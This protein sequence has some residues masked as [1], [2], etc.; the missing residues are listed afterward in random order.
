MKPRKLVTTTEVIPY[1]ELERSRDSLAKGPRFDEVLFTKQ[2][3]DGLIDDLIKTQ[4]P[5]YALPTN[6][7]IDSLASQLGI[8]SKT[9]SPVILDPESASKRLEAIQLLQKDARFSHET[10]ED[11]RQVVVLSK[12]D[13]ASLVSAA[14]IT[15]YFDEYAAIPEND[16]GA[17]YRDLSAFVG[18]T[19]WSSL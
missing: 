3:I 11:K 7:D 9:I 15:G 17:F 4:D 10:I 1:V 18:V 13:V 12:P 5:E 19:T 14:A 6:A 8:D 16:R 2:L